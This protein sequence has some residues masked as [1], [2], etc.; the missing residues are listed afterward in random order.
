MTNQSLR[1]R[2]RLDDTRSKSA[3]VTQIILMAIEQG[4]IKIGDPD[5]LSKR[6]ANYIPFWA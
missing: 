3:I 5:S 4:Q 6:Y 2:F 1:E